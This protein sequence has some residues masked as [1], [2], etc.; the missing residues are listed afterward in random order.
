M[1]LVSNS[2]RYRLPALFRMARDSDTVLRKRWSTLCGEG[3]PP[4]PAGHDRALLADECPCMRC[5]SLSRT[6]RRHYMREA[7]SK[8]LPLAQFPSAEHC[9]SF[10]RASFPSDVWYLVL[11]HSDNYPSFG[12]AL[13]GFSAS[14]RT[15]YWLCYWQYRRRRVLHFRMAML[16]ALYNAMFQLNRNTHFVRRLLDKFD[17]RDPALACWLPMRELGVLL[18]GMLLGHALPLGTPGVTET[19]NRLSEQSRLIS[20]VYDNRS[21]WPFTPGDIKD[22][23]LL[24]AIARGDLMVQIGALAVHH[25]VARWD[26]CRVPLLRMLYSPFVAESSALFPRELPANIQQLADLEVGPTFLTQFFPD[27]VVDVA[28]PYHF[29][30]HCARAVMRTTSTLMWLHKQP[31][32]IL[33]HTHPSFLPESCIALFE[34]Y[35]TQAPA[36]F[37]A[38]HYMLTGKRKA[39]VLEQ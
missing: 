30:P 17:L 27:A 33:A 14:C 16:H 6:F 32:P 18:G 15:A 22:I 21:T 4:T 11:R 38:K 34:W 26:L 31:T 29:V 9:A 20:L 3:V 23:P 28:L 19:K 35:R 13:M 8:P 39:V 5:A 37:E 12:S 7:I 1:A 2:S 25:C 10:H 36:Y 24:Y